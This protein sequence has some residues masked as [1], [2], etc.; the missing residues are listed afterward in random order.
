MKIF[1]KK[2][3]KKKKEKQINYPAT[4]TVQRNKNNKKIKRKRS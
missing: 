3:P 2:N 1:K 4:P